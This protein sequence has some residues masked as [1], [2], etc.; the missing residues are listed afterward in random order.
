MQLLKNHAHIHGFEDYNIVALG[1]SCFYD[2]FEF[3][4]PYSYDNNTGSYLTTKDLSVNV[5]NKESPSYSWVKTVAFEPEL[6]TNHK[7]LLD[8]AKKVF[9]HQSCKLSRSMMAEKYKKSLNP[10]KITT[11]NTIIYYTRRF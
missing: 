7:E 9:T 2:T 3:S 8:T 4:L 5:Y 6:A 1:D 11:E 10:F